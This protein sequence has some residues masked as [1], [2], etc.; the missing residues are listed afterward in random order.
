MTAALKVFS[1]D[2]SECGGVCLGQCRLHGEGAFPIVSAPPLT[3]PAGGVAAQ[4]DTQIH[5]DPEDLPG[6]LVC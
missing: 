6:V 4:L 3:T 2:H 1:G 5:S